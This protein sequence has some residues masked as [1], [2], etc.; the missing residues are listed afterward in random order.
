MHVKVG[1]V[2]ESNNLR[3][4]KRELQ[5][6]KL[7]AIDTE[8]TG[9]DPFKHQVR[10]VQI[11]TGEKCF[12]LDLFKLNRKEVA[13]LING[14]LHDSKVI[15]VLHNAKFDFKMMTT[16]GVNFRDAVQVF[17]TYIAGKILK[18]GTNYS[19]SLATLA[20]DYLGVTLD[21]SNQVSNWG[22]Q[23]YREQI[24]YA[25][26]DAII[27]LQLYHVLASGLT[28]NHLVR[29]AQIEFDCIPAIAQLELNG[30]QIDKDAWLAAA[31][32]EQDALGD[33]ETALRADLGDINFRS[34]QQVCKAL[35]N[36]V[37]FNVTSRE[38]KSLIDMVNSYEPRPDMFG[39]VIDWRPTVIKLLQHSQAAK[40]VGTYGATFLDNVHSVTGRIHSDYKQIDTKTARFSSSNPN[41]QNIPRSSALRSAFTAPD[42]YVLSCLDYSQIELRILCSLSGDSEFRHAFENNLD[43][44]SAMAAAMFKV[45]VDKVSNEQRHAAKTINFG[46]PYGMGAGKLSATLGITQT[47]AKVMLS[48]YYDAHPELVAWFESQVDYFERYDCVRSASGR[49][50]ALP[51]WRRGNDEHH[52]AV[53]A[54][55]NF[56]IQSTS[57]D[58]MKVAIAMMYRYLPAEVK[59]VN[60][61]HDEIVLEVPVDMAEDVHEEQRRIMVRA[62]QQFMTDVPVKVEGAISKHWSK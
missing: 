56:P 13:G 39:K 33:L 11:A 28:A 21:K 8:T 43:L 3:V 20:S 2:S 14:L 30:I 53:Q 42:G 6:A 25:A 32:K 61:V 40:F 15:K 24:E 10:L 9:L 62:A 22:G 54:S 45:P 17:D 57:A 31:L 47:E 7:V 26:L 12:V 60:Q 59:L 16:F 29:A 38:K 55:K 34:N 18:G 19:C 37:G 58:I 52:I 1:Y 46:V 5:L 35:S 4:V 48:K 36:I 49:I 27:T 41:L 23:V 50:R 51:N 44:H